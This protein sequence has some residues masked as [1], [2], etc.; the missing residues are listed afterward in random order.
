MCIRDSYFIF[1]NWS[2]LLDTRVHALMLRVGS[3]D[4][5]EAEA[6]LGGAGEEDQHRSSTLYQ[7]L[8]QLC[9][10]KALKE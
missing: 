1:G 9:K 8:A 4:T 7:L 3:T 6:L 2:Q 5:A 10:G